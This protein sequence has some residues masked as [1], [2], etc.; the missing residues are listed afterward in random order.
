MQKE[1]LYCIL[2][3]SKLVL[4]QKIVEASCDTILLRQVFRSLSNLPAA[5]L[6]FRYKLID[7]QFK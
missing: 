3:V 2:A 1:I 5:K 4:E 7:Y 6:V